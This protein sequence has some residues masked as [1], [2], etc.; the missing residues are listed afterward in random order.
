MV[1]LLLFQ[2]RNLN[3]E[4]EVDSVLGIHNSGPS[5]SNFHTDNNNTSSSHHNISPIPQNGSRTTQKSQSAHHRKSQH[6]SQAN[7]RPH[8]QTAKRSRAQDATIQ[9]K[10]FFGHDGSH[11]KDSGESSG[12]SGI[13]KGRE[14]GEETGIGRKGFCAAEG[15]EESC[16]WEVKTG[17]DMGYG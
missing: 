2:L 6:Q 4:E 13:A 15:S 9:E 5:T 16:W 11:R 3:V 10:A 14:E 17:G 1:L 7:G 8:H 12:T